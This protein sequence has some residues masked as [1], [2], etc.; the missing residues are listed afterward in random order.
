M[1]N[2]DIVIC[3]AGVV[4][5]S[6]AYH[7]ALRGMTPLVVERERVAYG[8]SGTAAG[9]LTPPQPVDLRGPLGPLL[10]RSI[11]LHRGLAREL[12]GA[13]RYDYREMPAAL[14]AQNEHE[15]G[16]L[17]RSN[18]GAFEEAP[19]AWTDRAGFG[20][21]RVEGAA[22]ID[23]GKFTATLL[24]EARARG[25]ALLHGDVQGVRTEGRRVSGL[26]VS[27]ETVETS[28]VVVAMGPWSPE[29]ESWLRLPLPVTPLKGQIL[30]Y[31]IAN[32]PE[33]EFATI[34]GN[35]AVRKPTGVV[36]AGTTEEEAGFDLAS[37]DEALESIQA[38]ACSLSSH[39][40]G[41]EPFE[42]TACLRPLSRDGLPLLGP[43]GHIDGAYVATG[44]GRKG[45]M[46]S[47]ASGEAM[48]ELITTGRS[49]T[50]DLSPFAPGRFRAAPKGK[51]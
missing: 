15:A 50:V 30:R 14:V 3:G 43:A 1:T 9:L 31:R 35:Y 29:A 20:G 46:L 23:P 8:A 2:A 28:R 45:I 38:W 25:A 13:T 12:D 40:D 22:Q 24:E 32:A 36:Y 51:Q 6:I 21:L 7:L 19:S 42:R 5:A 47:T 39:F 18:P 11:E 48:A 41:Q 33:G 17:R 16:V 34:D 44:H 26:I 10:E 37:T 49:T 4:G 27:A